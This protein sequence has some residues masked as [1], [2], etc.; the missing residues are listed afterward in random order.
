M[1]SILLKNKL[2]GD[3][4]IFL[5]DNSIIAYKGQ[6]IDRYIDRGGY[7][8]SSDGIAMLASNIRDTIDKALNLLPSNSRRRYGDGRG[9]PF[10]GRYRHGHGRGRWQ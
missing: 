9:Q 1:I 5:C 10:R 4:S 8:L 3:N 7:H 6:V 2:R